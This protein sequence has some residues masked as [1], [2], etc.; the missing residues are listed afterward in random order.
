MCSF[1]INSFEIKNTFD[2]EVEYV[3][4]L[5]NMYGNIDSIRRCKRHIILKAGDTYNKVLTIKRFFT[6]HC[7][8]M[9]KMTRSKIQWITNKSINSNKYNSN[10]SMLTFNNF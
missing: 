2:F 7:Y 6:S 3:L 4:I 5:L 8:H 10:K 1:L 9:K